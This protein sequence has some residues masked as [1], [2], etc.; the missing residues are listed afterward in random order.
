MD[1]SRQSIELKRLARRYIWWE[2]PER[3]L[4]SPERVI[5]QTMTLGT[6]SDLDCLV[7]LVTPR[8][9]RHTLEVAMPGWFD[10]KAWAFWHYRLG[11]TDPGENP[12]PLPV[13]KTA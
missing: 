9:L 7:R 3:A 8:T 5:A 12:P 13:R 10:A 11:L 2:T 1:S 4:E 6:L